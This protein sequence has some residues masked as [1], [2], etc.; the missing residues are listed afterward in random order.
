MPPAQTRLVE[1]PFKYDPSVLPCLLVQ[2]SINGQPPLP[3]EVDTGTTGVLLT[4]E[5][6]AAKKLG[7]PF[8][9]TNK[10]TYLPGQPGQK[11]VTSTV[12]KTVEILGVK[13]S[14]HFKLTLKPPRG[15]GP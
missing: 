14:D 15:D 8:L 3:F 7:L 1:L 5:P 9:V 11:T 10:D 6:W 4:V 2:V 13:K 12:L